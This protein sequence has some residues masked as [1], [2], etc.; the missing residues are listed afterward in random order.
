MTINFYGDIALHNIEPNSFSL[1][2]ELKKILAQGHLNIGNFECPVTKCD[3]KIEDHPVHLKCGSINL[4]ILEGF[5]AFSLANNHLMDYGLN[6]LLDTIENLRKNGFEYFGGGLNQDEATKPLVLSKENIKVAL[7]GVTRFSFSKNKS[8]GPA[9]DSIFRLRKSIKR[10]KKEKCFVVIYFHWGYEYVP[11]PAPRERR[12]AHQCIDFGA[13]LIIGAHP[14]IL[15]GIEKYKN[16]NIFYSL[17]NFIFD[18]QVFKG[19]AYYESD[20]RILKSLV[21]SVEISDTYEYTYQ[22]HPCKIYDH[23]VELL[24]GMEKDSLEKELDEISSVYHESYLSYLKKY[25]RY[26]AEISSQNKKILINYT[27]KEKRNL[28]KML[29]IYSRANYQDVLNKLVGIL[30]KS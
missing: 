21:L 3:D 9:R 30:W 10:L 15:Q 25:F 7:I 4:K 29:K 12:I 23:G 18:P 19:L 28:W 27:L 11:Y 17:G 14:H 22:I 16:K 20:P 6:G 2:E 13:D 8:P 1:S 5:Y 26:A 24:A